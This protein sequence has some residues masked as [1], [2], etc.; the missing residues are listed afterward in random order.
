MRRLAGHLLILGALVPAAFAQSERPAPRFGSQTEL[1]QID[2]RVTGKGGERVLDLARE[3]FLVLEDGKPQTVSHF[4]RRAGPGFGGTTLEMDKPAASVDTPL[5][6]LDVPGRLTVV[7]V[8]TQS[9]DPST[10]LNMKQKLLG[11]LD[12][13]VGRDDQVALVTTSGLMLQPFTNDRDLLR[14]AVERVRAADMKASPFAERPEMTTY[15]ADLI[16]RNDQGARQEYARRLRLEDA[17]LPPQMV[18]AITN[19]RARRIAAEAARNARTTLGALEGLLRPLAAFP[20]RKTLVLLSN[21][22]FTQEDERPLLQS[23][24]AVATRAGVVIYSLDARGL[25]VSS[26]AGPVGDAAVGGRPSIITGATFDYSWLGFEA[27]RNGLNV[28]ARDTGGLPIFNVDLAVGLKKVLADSEAGYVLGYEPASRPGDERYHKIEVKVPGRSGLEVRAQR[29]YFGRAAAAKR[30]ASGRK[31]AASTPAAPS[32]LRDA[33]V[34]LMARHELPIDLAAGYADTDAG[35][36]VVIT[37]RVR[38]EPV[39]T[40]PLGTRK[41]EVLGVIYDEQGQPLS[42][43]NDALEATGGDRLTFDTHTT[44]PPGRYQVRAAAGDGTRFGTTSVWTEVP[45]LSQ[46]TFTL[47]DLFV[48]EG[49]APPRPVGSGHV[50]ARATPVEFTLFACN[51]KGD[52]A[53]HADVVFGMML[54]AGDRVV[55]EDPPFVVTVPI[56][57][58]R[59][60]RVGFSRDFALAALNPG[61]YTVRIDVV[62]RIAQATLRRE[63]GFRVE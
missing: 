12:E 45:D 35:P 4:A 16:L 50:F 28:L 44:L 54:L 21:G 17:A 62:D 41:V 55:A 56:G 43:F 57:D 37:A 39:A 23:V 20:G 36:T 52:S 14:R 59:P 1:I 42:N 40:A 7:A 60:P 33:L 5:P 18:E 19:T 6:E 30:A 48:T 26:P 63:L 32:P 2:V 49:D 9:L 3:D 47:T 24:T 8:D 51:A 10:F 38:P 31:E 29:G 61:D 15:Q 58:A 13:R 22:F 34:S 46:G 25:A 53:R 11:F 27:D